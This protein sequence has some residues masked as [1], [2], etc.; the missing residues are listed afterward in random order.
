MTDPEQQRVILL[1]SICERS[2]E[3]L[4]SLVQPRKLTELICSQLRE[5]LRSHFC[6]ESNEILHRFHFY[7]RAQR[8]GESV[9]EFLVDLRRL[10]ANCNFAELDNMLRDRLVCGIRDESIQRR[11]FAE[12]KLD[13]STALSLIHIIEAAQKDVRSI[14]SHQQPELRIDQLRIGQR[15][16]RADPWQPDI[17]TQSLCYRCLD[18][19]HN[20]HNCPFKNAK[21]LRC[22][23]VGHTKRACRAKPVFRGGERLPLPPTLKRHNART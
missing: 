9:S 18:G 12:K 1:T 14:R 20:S 7:T 17:A 11:L 3:L 8:E 19:R 16:G 10:S 15:N 5:K 21:C 2:Y 13:F 6:P 4:R 23:R 22:Q